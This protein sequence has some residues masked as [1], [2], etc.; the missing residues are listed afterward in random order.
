MTTRQQTQQQTRPDARKIRHVR[1]SEREWT[2]AAAKANADGYTISEVVRLLLRD[3][4]A[5]RVEV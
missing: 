1:M 4:V 3:Y 2:E 5:G